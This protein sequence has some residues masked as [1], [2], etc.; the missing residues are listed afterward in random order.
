M[1]ISEETVKRLELPLKP[2]TEL[3]EVFNTD[4]SQSGQKPI[5]DYVDI[6]LDTQGYQEQI[7]A[8]VTTLESADFFL[9]HD[10]LTYYNPEIDW[11]NG[12]IKFTR[13]PLSCKILHH[14]ICIKSHIQRLQEPEIDEEEEKLPNLTSAEDLLDYMKEYT[15]LFNKINFNQLLACTQWDHEIKLTDNIPLELKAK[16]Y[17]MTLKEEEE[18]NTFIDENLKSGRIHISKSQYTAPC[19]FI[20]KKDGLK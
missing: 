17:P 13:C 9:G 12:I 10:W 6:T 15:H 16:I 4:G 7:K 3:F 8:V 18:L 20:L 2:I 1:C 5:T 14:N 19:F 11:N